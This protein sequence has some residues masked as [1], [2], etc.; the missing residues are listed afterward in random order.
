MLC[1]LSIWS[2]GICGAYASEGSLV[3][4]FKTSDLSFNALVH[5]SESTSPPINIT[6]DIKVVNRVFDG[7]NFTGF[8]IP[9]NY[10]TSGQAFDITFSL[11]DNFTLRAEHEYNINFS[12]RQYFNLSAN[13]NASLYIYNSD[14]SLYKQKVLYTKNIMGYS[15][16]DLDFNFILSKS[17][18]PDSYYC[19]LEFTFKQ[20]TSGNANS[21]SDQAFYISEY[22]TL[23]DL[24]DDSGWFQKIINAIT[25]IPE[26]IKSFFTNL[27]S[28][29][30]SFFTDLWDK[31]RTQFENI[32]KWFKELGDKIGQYFE[33]L[34][35]D[36]IEGIKRLF[37]PEDGF[38]EQKKT[39]LETFLSE[40]FG[41]LWT[42][43][44]IIISTIRQLLTISPQEPTITMPAIQFEWEGKII[45]L[46]EPMTVHFNDYIGSGTP[47]HT[48][49]Q[50]YRTFVTIFL[51]FLFLQY[52]V[53]KYHYI[54]GKDGEAVTE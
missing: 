52:C 20:H 13:F 8:L 24:D 22:I 53:N 12:F 28:T 30:G 29:I 51:I 18:L 40:H 39:E 2:F 32:G 11:F 41:I 54:F 14:G 9:N 5:A 44:D 17:D 19:R 43:P 21:S 42:A 1:F 33:N 10:Y 4:T 23:T 48:L 38:F 16:T 31:L 26:K 37:I 46:T 34:Y 49:Y 36:I 7:K 47:L 3:Q 25:S 35:N 6:Y 27:G 50:F 45:T 15:T